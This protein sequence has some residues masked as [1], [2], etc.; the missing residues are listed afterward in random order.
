MLKPV[1]ALLI[2]VLA[3][4]V[5]CISTQPSLARSAVPA[6]ATGYVGAIV[7][8]DTV[9]GFGLGLRDLADHDYVLPLENGVVL[10]ALPPGTYRVAYWVTFAALTHERLTQQDIPPAES[11]ATPFVLAPG[12]VMLLGDLF[13]DRLGMFSRT[14]TIQ[15]MPISAGDAALKFRTEYRGFAAAPIDCL[16]CTR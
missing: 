15:T 11:F 1:Q 13:S 14:Y 7:T 8:K 3:T 10:I 6:P 16:A 12:H 2:L 4:S 9:A 5:G